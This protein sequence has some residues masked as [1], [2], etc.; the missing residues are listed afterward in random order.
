MHPQVG[1][2]A[3]F[4][5][6]WL[7]AAV[8]GGGSAVWLMYRSGLSDYQVAVA[9]YSRVA[10]LLIGS[11]ILYLIEAWPVWTADRAAIMAALFSEQMRI[12]GGILLALAIGPWVARASGVRY[13]ALADTIVPAAGLMIVG[14]RTGCFL[15]GCC[16]GTPS[17]LPWAVRFPVLSEA[18]AWQ[19]QQGLLSAGLPESLPVHPLQ[20]YFAVAGLL[21]FAGLAAYQPYKRYEGEVLLL[22]ALSFLWSTWLL[23]TMRARPHVL[24]QYVVLGAAIATTTLTA[25][26][27][28]GRRVRRSTAARIT[29]E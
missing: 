16:F 28:L 7:L 18:Y 6:G 3:G 10:A 9:F 24:T 19:L 12:P 14:I 21:L 22:F 23:E 8:L 11:K 4:V 17:A 2:L 13:L 5:V 1:P 15:E 27:E 20:L 29:A 26:I 25:A